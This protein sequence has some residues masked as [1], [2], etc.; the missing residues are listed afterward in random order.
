MMFYNYLLLSNAID[1]K[2]SLHRYLAD[3]AL[4]DIYWF[5]GSQLHLAPTP[6]PRVSKPLTGS[7]AVERRYHFNTGMSRPY[8]TVTV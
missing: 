3:V 6:L 8:E 5:V 7:S 2:D 4:V 1:N